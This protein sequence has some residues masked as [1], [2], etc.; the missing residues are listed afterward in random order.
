MYCM[1]SNYDELQFFSTT[2]TI[3]RLGEHNIKSTNDGADTQDIRIGSIIRHP[4]FKPPAKY[5]DI[6]LLRL[7]TSAR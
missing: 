5:N 1:H 6:A 4:D 3:V 2:P 7:A